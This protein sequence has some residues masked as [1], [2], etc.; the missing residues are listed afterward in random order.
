[1]IN[2]TPQQIK[3]IAENLE[4]GFRCFC[5]RKTGTVVTLS[6]SQDYLLDEDYEVDEDEDNDFLEE[7]K[8]ELKDLRDNWMDYFEIEKPETHEAFK[9]MEHFVD[10]LNDSNPLR[11]QLIN[12]LNRKGPFGN[13][14]HLIENAGAERQAWFDFRDK[15]MRQYVRNQIHIENKD[16]MW[17]LSE[18]KGDDQAADEN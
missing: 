15:A 5:N 3:E 2:L 10:T 4:C 9:V 11:N 7:Y 17:D 1:M 12:A 8:E 13:F 16:G 6:P 18:E 14:K